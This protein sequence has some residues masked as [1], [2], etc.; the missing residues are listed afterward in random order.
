M[1]TP[2]LNPQS[3]PVP[4]LS[5]ILVLVLAC[6]CLI[7]LS[8]QAQQTHEGFSEKKTEKVGLNYLLYLPPGYENNKSERWPLVV[9]LHGAGERGNDLNLVKVH[10]PP[11]LVEAG[12]SFPFI[13]VSPQCPEDDWWPWQPVMELIEH[14]K[15]KQRVDP[16]RVYLTGLSMGGYGTWHFATRYPDKFAAVAPI[17]G[18]G[19]PYLC[20]RMPHLPVW[21]FHG[22]KDQTVPLEESSRMI[23]A[24]KKAGSTTA[25]LT[26]YPEATHDSWTEA[27]NTKEL[28]D[29][30]L[31]QRRK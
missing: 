28:Y 24:L 15:K 23:E 5:V 4:V 21:A 13:L 25:K 19:T 27:Y 2:L 18:G 26:V 31:S 30:L 12:E 22:A 7:P 3:F 20:K 6:V 8:A 17:C 14:I 11:K 10:G 16:D 9:F 1:K 29:W